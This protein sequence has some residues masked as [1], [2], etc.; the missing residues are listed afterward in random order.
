[1]ILHSYSTGVRDRFTGGLL[2][3]CVGVAQSVERGLETPEVSGS[4]PDSHTKRKR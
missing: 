1:M 3:S 4:T 2:A